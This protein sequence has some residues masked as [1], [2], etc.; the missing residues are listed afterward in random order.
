MVPVEWYAPLA[1]PGVRSPPHAPGH[2][3][4]MLLIDRAS[5]RPETLRCIPHPHQVPSPDPPQMTLKW[6]APSA[7]PCSPQA[8]LMLQATPLTSRAQRGAPE[9]S[10][11]PQRS[12]SN[13]TISRESDCGNKG[14]VRKCYKAEVR[15]EKQ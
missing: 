11:S 5:A 6:P 13:Q 15:T 9:S 4:S 3:P 1:A 10:S 2:T 8:A 14:K 12:A 7:H